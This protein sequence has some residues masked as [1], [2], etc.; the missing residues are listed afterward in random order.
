MKSFF[1]KL[2]VALVAVSTVGQARA[3]QPARVAPVRPLYSVQSNYSMGLLPGQ[4]RY[5]HYPRHYGY[6]YHHASTAAEG[7]ARGIAAM[8]YARGHYN[9]LTAEARAIQAEA[10]ARAISDAIDNRQKA[11]ETYFAMRAANREA[12]AA[13]RGPRATPATLARIARQ[14]APERLGP[15]ELSSNT[16]EVSWPALLQSDEYVAYRTEL[17]EAFVQRASLGMITAEDRTSAR[18]AAKAM[19][20]ELKKHVREVGPME[21]AAAR[22]FIESLSYEAQLPV[23]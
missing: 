22:R 18:Q 13:L 19:L 3:Q 12:Q 6:G 4:Y 23:S 5:G 10:R 14:A 7:Y 1:T 17:D 20:A 11:A 15:T 9:R 21:Y 16:G 8:T 2:A